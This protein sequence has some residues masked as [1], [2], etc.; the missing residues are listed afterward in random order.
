MGGG[1]RGASSRPQDSQQTKL[2]AE[3]PEIGKAVVVDGK[4][5]NSTKEPTW[6]VEIL[7]PQSSGLNHSGRQ[8]SMCIRGPQ[9]LSRAQAEEDAAKLEKLAEGGETRAVK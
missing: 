3:R 2:P 5:R 7:M 1:A 6:R 4:P 8:R 9:R